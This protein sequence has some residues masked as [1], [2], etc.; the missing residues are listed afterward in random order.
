MKPIA[1][2]VLEL[3]LEDHTDTIT[4]LMFSPTGNELA[5][6]SDNGS[7]IIYEPLVRSL[8]YCTVFQ[9]GILSLAWDLQHLACLFVG[10]NDG[11]LAI[12]DDFKNQDPPSSVLTGIKSPIFSL[13]IDKYSGDIVI[14]VGS[15]I[16]IAK[17]ISPS[18]CCLSLLNCFDCLQAAIVRELCHN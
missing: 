10:C 11:T 13:S 3:T 1:P 8:K 2:F 12:I 9:G 5:S 7:I 14:T 4:A 6:G 16:H 18:T 15:E 17:E